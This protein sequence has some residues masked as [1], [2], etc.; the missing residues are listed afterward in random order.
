MCHTQTHQTHTEIQGDRKTET[1]TKIL[2]TKQKTE[3]RHN[4]FSIRDPS[5]LSVGR[6]VGW[7]VWDGF[8]LN[9]KLFALIFYYF[10]WS[11]LLLACLTITP[12]GFM[13]RTFLYIL[14][15]FFACCS[16]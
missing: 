12:L 16:L 5:M 10:I 15:L 4:I 6:S 1:E 2:N 3:E 8:F 14:V 13:I 9:K 11:F 7:F